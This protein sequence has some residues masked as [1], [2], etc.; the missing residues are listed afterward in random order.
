MHWCYCKNIFSIVFTDLLSCIKHCKI[1]TENYCTNE[2]ARKASLLKQLLFIKM[3]EGEN[4]RNFLGK[5]M[6]TVDKLAD[7][8]LEINE[9]LLVPFY[10]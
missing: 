7:T 6:K 5:F 9:G 2:P 8:D 4:I 1:S 3:K 10:H